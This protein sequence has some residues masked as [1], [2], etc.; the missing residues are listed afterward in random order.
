M[1]IR[2]ASIGLTIVVIFG[3]SDT[4]PSRVNIPT[5]AVDDGGGLYEPCEVALSEGK[6]TIPEPGVAQFV[7]KYKFNKAKPARFYSCDISFPGS[8]ARAVK[9]M[10]AWQLRDEG[11]IVDRLAVPK[12]GVGNFE[13]V[14]MEA[15]SGMAAYK[16]VSNV[17]KGMVE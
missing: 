11:I 1:R 6:V 12:E 8:Q 17:L 15:P 3:C 14:F 10:E 7:V 16:P 9:R 2:T 13:I 4:R 5:V